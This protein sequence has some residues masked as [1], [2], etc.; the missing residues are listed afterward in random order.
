MMFQTQGSGSFTAHQDLIRGGT[1]IDS[2]DSLVDDP[3]SSGAWG[4]NSP[5]GAKTNLI[6]TSLAYRKREGSVS[7]YRAISILGQQLPDAGRSL[8][9]GQHYVEV[10]RRP[11][12]KLNSTGALWNGFAVIGS[13]F[14]NPSQWGQH[15][16]SPPQQIFTDAQNG[17]L[18]EV[19]WVIPDA[20]NSDHPGYKSDKGPSWVACDRQRNWAEP[21]LELNGDHRRLGRLGRLLRSGGAAEARQSRRPGLSRA[22]DRRRRPTCR[23]NEISHTRVRLRQH[24]AV[25][26]R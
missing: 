8:R 14:N 13:F 18:P 11:P 7:V 6:T 22:D 5:P 2:T 9:D 26:R 19:S 21:V 16:I 12:M 25:H 10:L 3:T 20:L 1:E 23:Q 24:R 15:V 4:C 17:H